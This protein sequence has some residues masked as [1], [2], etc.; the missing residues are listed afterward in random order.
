MGGK[1]AASWQG[2]TNR[3]MTLIR[4]LHILR[5][6]SHCF[7]SVYGRSLSRSPWAIYLILNGSR[8]DGEDI[9][10]FRY[11]VIPHN[12]VGIKGFSCTPLPP[13][14]RRNS[15]FFSTLCLCL[16]A[17]E[18]PA[19]SANDRFRA[20]GTF[21]K[22]VQFFQSTKHKHEC[23]TIPKSSPHPSSNKNLRPLK[24]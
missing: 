6:S 20:Y 13:L 19:G 11:I 22:V 12:F 3:D 17:D 24:K 16:L 23:D 14:P 7:F 8:S 9:L 18:V 2:V 10:F 15:T 4:L 5:R 21:T 1:R